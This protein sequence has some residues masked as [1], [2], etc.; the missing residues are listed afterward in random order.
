[1]EVKTLRIFEQ[2][3]NLTFATASNLGKVKE[4]GGR[5]RISAHESQQSAYIINAECI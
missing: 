4:I 1:M 5:S 2:R 3:H